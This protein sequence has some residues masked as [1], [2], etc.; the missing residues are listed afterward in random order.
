MYYKEAPAPSIVRGGHRGGFPDVAQDDPRAADNT[1][2]RAPLPETARRESLTQLVL[3]RSKLSAREALL[4]R[5]VFPSILA[6]HYDQVCNQLRRRGLLDYEAED[7][8]QEVFF[9]LHT[10]IVEH[11]FPDNL[12]G[13][14]HTLTERKLLNHLRARRRAPVS[15]ELPS[16]GSEKPRSDLN[17]ER[18]LELRELARQLVDRLS[19]E[20]QSVIDKVILNGL[21]QRDAA[22]VLDLPEGTVKSRMIAAKQELL[23]LAKRLLPPSQRGPL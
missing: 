4:L 11:G 8:L 2:Q 7:L 20:H 9:T 5:E 13:R 10:Q 22:V 16:S 6:S 18:V 17:V 14:L 19:P 1:G 23:A 12:A 15:L 3:C 21:S